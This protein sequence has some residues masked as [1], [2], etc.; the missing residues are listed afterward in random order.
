MVTPPVPKEVNLDSLSYYK[1][2]SKYVLERH[3]RREEALRSGSKPVRTF[4]SGKG[5]KAREEVVYN[6]KDIYICRTVE[7]WYKEGKKVMVFT[8]PPDPFPGLF[9]FVRGNK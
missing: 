9:L 8:P 3:L 5:D 7:N 1:N 2:H 4:T 6:R